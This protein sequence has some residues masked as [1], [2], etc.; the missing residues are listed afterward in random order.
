MRRSGTSR[1]TT[2]AP[3]LDNWIGKSPSTVATIHSALNG[4]FSWLYLESEIDANPMARVARP[5]RPRPGD[6][7][8]VIVTP[9]DVERMFAAVETWQELLCLS[10]LAYTGI[11]RASAAGLRWR[12]V[13]LASGTIRVREKGNKVSTKPVSNELLE[14]LRAAVESDEVACRG[15]DY[16]I[17][18]RRAATVRRKERSDKVIW[19]TMVESG[20]PDRRQGH[21]PR[22]QASVRGLVPDESSGRVGVAPGAD[23]SLADRHDGGLPASAQSRCW[24]WRL[25]GISPGTEPPGFSRITRKGPY[26]IRTRAAAVRGRCPRPLDEWAV[27]RGSVPNP[28]E[29]ASGRGVL[30]GW[31]RARYRRRG[32]RCGP[33]GCGG[34]PRRSR[35]AR[36]SGRGG[37]GAS[38][39]AP[40]RPDP[41]G[42]ER[43]QPPHRAAAGDRS[44]AVAMSQGDTYH[45]A[46]AVGTRPRGRVPHFADETFDRSERTSSRACTTTGPSC[47]PSR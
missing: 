8:V 29:G 16:V 38:R 4:L 26:G 39:S 21:C 14:I 18:N 6:V 3:F 2:V 13:D 22:S 31:G 1:R 25:S 37:A 44:F 23:E 45:V 19:E 20:E 34:S 40:T 28:A 43:R 46:R 47:C 15:D 12:E 11:R 17:P 24:R 41:H 32:R 36:R 35:A 7:E 10:V 27:R 9:H 42:S 30:R 33:R 5:R